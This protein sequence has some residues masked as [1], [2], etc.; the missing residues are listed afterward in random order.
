VDGLPPNTA[1]F[2]DPSARREQETQVR[3]QLQRAFGEHVLVAAR[4]T[5]TRNRSTADV[6][7]YTRNVFGLSV[8]IGWGD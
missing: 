8:R 6:F 5:R 4:W 7:D 1:Y 3:V 2:L